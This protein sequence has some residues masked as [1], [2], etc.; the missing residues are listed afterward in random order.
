MYDNIPVARYAPGRPVPENA[1]ANFD[2]LYGRGTGDDG[3]VRRHTARSEDGDRSDPRL[4]FACA[5]VVLFARPRYL[6][7]RHHAAGD[8]DR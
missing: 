5:M 3:A 6:F 7:K 1:R 2:P 8:S 4:V